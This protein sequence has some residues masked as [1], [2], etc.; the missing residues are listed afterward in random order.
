[1]NF[2]N[3]LYNGDGQHG[4]GPVR[5]K[6]LSISWGMG[7]G[8]KRSDSWLAIY[9]GHS[10]EVGK[11]LVSRQGQEVGFLKL[12]KTVNSPNTGFRQLPTHKTQADFI[13]R[14]DPRSVLK[15][16]FTTKTS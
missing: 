10:A 4:E 9:G 5:R 12:F 6:N 2:S 8:G 14:N 15:V 7:V 1:M 13:T 16:T 11:V 3:T